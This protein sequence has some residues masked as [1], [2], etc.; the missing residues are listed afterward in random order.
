MKNLDRPRKFSTVREN[1]RPSE[2]I[3]DRPRKISTVREKSRL[4]ENPKWL[5]IEYRLLR[6]LSRCQ[7]IRPIRRMT[8]ISDPELSWSYSSPECNLG[9]I[10]YIPLIVY[11]LS[12]I[13]SIARLSIDLFLLCPNM[14]R[15]EYFRMLEFKTDITKIT[16]LS[17]SRPTGIANAASRLI[18][19]NVNFV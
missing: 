6:R 16:K 12:K 14:T 4:S 8:P 1:S 11:A 9:N 3:L 2:K 5:S 19:R 7:V 15:A 18:D 10:S 13:L 17:T